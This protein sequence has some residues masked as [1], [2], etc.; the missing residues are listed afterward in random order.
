MDFTSPDLEGLNISRN[1]DGTYTGTKEVNIYNET[2][3]MT[4][5]S[6]LKYPRLHIKW[7]NNIEFG[8]VDDIIAMPASV[9]GT[10]GSDDTLWNLTVP[11][12]DFRDCSNCANYNDPDEVDNGCYMCCKGLENNFL[13]IDEAIEYFKE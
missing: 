8:I 13:P 4:Y 2:T 12:N 1:N 5:N 7:E 11:D 10:T 6:F 9:I 3:G